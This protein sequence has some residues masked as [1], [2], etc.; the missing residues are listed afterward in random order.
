[1]SFSHPPN[2]PLHPLPPLNSQPVLLTTANSHHPLTSPLP[3]HSTASSFLCS[4]SPSS[5]FASFFK[6][7]QM[8]RLLL[9]L[10][11]DSSVHTSKALIPSPPLPFPLCPLLTS[12]HPPPPSP[13]SPLLAFSS[14]SY[15]SFSIST[16]FLS[17]SPHVS[18]LFQLS[19]LTPTYNSIH[20]SIS[21]SNTSS[22]TSPTIRPPTP[23]ISPSPAPFAS[24][25]SSPSYSS[26]SLPISTFR[27]SNYLP[28]IHPTIPIPGI[29]FSQF[30]L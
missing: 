15:F 18:S 27:G 1:M 16:G 11:Y 10:S 24:S 22:P 6:S 26:S 25:I 4:F 19:H 9:S 21:P 23:T 17:S 28:N 12:P 30:L 7:T 3:F 29:K 5:F 8:H 20:V 14:H 2:C 13:P